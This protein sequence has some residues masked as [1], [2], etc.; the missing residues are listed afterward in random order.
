LAYGVVAVLFSWPLPRLLFTHLTGSPSGD[1]GVYV[2]NI[3]LFRHELLTDGNPFWTSHIFSL[4][5]RVD[6]GLHNYTTFADLLA[7]PLLPVL[8][9]VGTFNVVFLFTRVLT[10]YATFLLARRLVPSDPVAWLAGLLFAW[11][12]VMVARGTGHFSLVAAAPLPIMI[13]VLLRLRERMQLRWAVAAGCVV[14][15]AVFCDAYYGVYCVMLALFYAG[16]ETLTVIRQPRPAGESC[17]LGCIWLDVLILCVASLIAGILLTGGTAWDVF[18]QRVTVRSLHTPVLLLTVLVVSRTVVALRPRLRWFMPLP[19]RHAV[20]LV[21]ATACAATVLL[22]PVLYAVGS[23][24]RDGRFDNPQ[25]FWRTSPAGLDLLALVIPN[26]NHPWLGQPTADWLASLPRG[27]IG[28]VGSLSLVALLVIAVAVWRSGFRPPRFWTVLTI[29]FGLLALGPFI[30]VAGVATYVPTPWALLRYVPLIGSARAP[31]RFAIVCM[32]GFSILF[33]YALH[34]LTKDRPR[35]WRMIALAGMLLAL[36]LTP[37]PRQLHSAAVPAIYQTIAAD[38]G[39][40]SILELPVGVRDGV[41]STGNFSA[42]TQYYQTA[43]GKPLVG[44]YLSR[45]SKKRVG[46]YRSIAVIDALMTLS[47]GRNP[48][49]EQDRRAWAGRDRF[50]KRSNIG[51]VVIDTTQATPEL[52]HYAIRLL[53]LVLV[54]QSDGRELYMPLR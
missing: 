48:T 27:Y 39:H 14:A 22:S 52:R 7:L 41:S 8:G 38:P 26:P 1:T 44:G 30:R 5:P 4:T 17:G 23:R 46:E 3:W 29:G 20:K 12:P 10:A 33:A 19:P 16:G 32:L 24:I 36:E 40:F 45:V 21:A 49:P 37:A 13:L 42:L 9:V 6:L 35:R 11:S 25:I 18:G 47:E 15:W 31:S 54:R 50:L 2:W 28:N 53:D 51:Y 43:H 34:H